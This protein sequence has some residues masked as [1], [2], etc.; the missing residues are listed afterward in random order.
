MNKLIEIIETKGENL[1]ELYAAFTSKSK[2]QV[3]SKFSNER[4]RKLSG[5]TLAESLREK[6]KI[7]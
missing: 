4:R 1:E 7:K 2:D 5:M 6:A 3:K